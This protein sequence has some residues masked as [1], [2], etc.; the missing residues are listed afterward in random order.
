MRDCSYV[1]MRGSIC[2][3]TFDGRESIHAARTL[4]VP[5]TSG[6]QLADWLRFVRL[7]LHCAAAVSLMSHLAEFINDI[8]TIVTQSALFGLATEVRHRSC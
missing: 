5:P 6:C 2:L 1:C 7:R 4:A 8:D 3:V